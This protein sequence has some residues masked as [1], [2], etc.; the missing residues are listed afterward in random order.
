VRAQIH[1][2]RTGEFLRFEERTPE[3]GESFCDRCGDCLHCYRDGC[4]ENGC[5][6]PGVECLW[7]IY[8][9][10]TLTPTPPTKGAP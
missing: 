7:V 2:E 8:E 6:T 10:A 3:C 5:W 9:D 4:Y 1:D